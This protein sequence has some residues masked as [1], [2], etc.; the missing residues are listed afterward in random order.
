VGHLP[1]PDLYMPFPFRTSP[2]LDAAR[3]YA[4]GWARRMGMF[5]SVPGVELGGVWDERR[6]L[7]FDFAHCAAMIHADASPEQLNL[8]SDWLAWGTYGDDYFPLV[9]GTTRDLVGAKLC[10]DRLPAFMPLDAG[11]TPE[12]TNAIER[13]LGD[14]WRRTAG[15]MTVSARRQFRTAVED[16]TSS[17][18]WELANQAQHRIPDPID[19]VEMRRK[20][21]GSDMTMGLA[22]L[23]HSD[24]V[25][26]EIYRTRVMRELDTAAQD[27]ACFTNDLFSYQKE[28]E[29]EGEAHNLVLVVENF[30]AVDRIKARDIVA[31]LMTTRMQQFE[32]IVASDLPVLFDEFELAESVRRLLTRHADDLKEW[33]SGILE[34]HRRCARYTE[35]ELRRGRGPV[36][37]GVSRCCPRGWAPLRCG[38]RHRLGRAGR[39]DRVAARPDPRSTEHGAGFG[40]FPERSQH[41][42]VPVAA[43]EAQDEAG[44]SGAVL[45]GQSAFVRLGDLPGDR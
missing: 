24:V 11:A 41:S 21:F 26:A 17:W 1:L 32:H 35:A 15:P 29:F 20:T 36:P 44:S 18:L 34:W 12:P 28:I 7:G 37:S 19:Y 5:D 23:A 10:D 16:M 25:P 4:V 39:I 45:D 43:R 14:L 31:D 42:E 33:M 38:S 8:S 22:R 40:E 2:H 9:F 6:F 27:Y 13:G 3:R 30:L